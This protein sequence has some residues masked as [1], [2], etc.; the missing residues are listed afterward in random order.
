LRG[1]GVGATGFGVGFL[2]GSIFTLCAAKRSGHVIKTPNPTPINNNAQA[3]KTVAFI[4]FGSL[5]TDGVDLENERLVATL[6]RR[7]GQDVVQH[8]GASLTQTRI[9]QINYDLAGLIAFERP[10]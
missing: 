9:N 3:V 2:P 7:N 10:H 8:S 1:V 6:L 5:P 4:A